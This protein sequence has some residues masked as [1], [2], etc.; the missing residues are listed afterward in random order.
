MPK[1]SFSQE[2]PLGFKNADKADPQVIGEELDRIAD[3]HEGKLKAAYVIEEAIS[4][5]H[6]LH[7]H[8]EWNNA[9]AA[10]QYR[11]D[12]ARALIRV[13]R[14]LVDDKPVPVR[15]FMSIT[16]SKGRSYRKVTEVIT[17]QRLQLLALEQAD[18][19]FASWAQRLADYQDICDLV[20]LV[21]DKL[22]RRAEEIRTTM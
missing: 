16:D 9:V 15:S 2:E 11:L 21:R 5:R 3:K 12:Q 1:Y 18:R 20:S 8:F 22:S 19:D 4:P 6:V 14:Q 10:D 7:K 17:D 13:V